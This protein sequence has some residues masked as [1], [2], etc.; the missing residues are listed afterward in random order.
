M[1]LEDVGILKLPTGIHINQLVVNWWFGI[2]SGVPLS[3][4]SL[5]S[6]KTTQI[7]Q[8]TIRWINPPPQKKTWKIHTPL[9]PWLC[10]DRFLQVASWISPWALHHVRVT[11]AQSTAIGIGLQIE[12][13]FD[14]NEFK[15][16]KKRRGSRPKQ[17]TT[18]NH[19][20]L[21]WME[22]V[23]WR[24]FPKHGVRKNKWCFRGFKKGLQFIYSIL[25]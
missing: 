16:E 2:R 6:T 20:I 17:T 11:T 1:M 18:Q 9:P 5:S 19:I 13:K 21:E 3:L 24:C 22:Y 25:L 23:V 8:I 7:Q 12:G 4:Q 14:M 10:N 15:L